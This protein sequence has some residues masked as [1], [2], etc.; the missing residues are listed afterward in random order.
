[1]RATPVQIS[2][3]ALSMALVLTAVSGRLGLTDLLSGA[4]G[5]DL[6]AAG[7]LCVGFAVGAG[8]V[9]GIAH[10]TSADELIASAVD[11]LDLPA[12]C[13]GISL[14]DHLRAGD[15]VRLEPGDDRCGLRSVERLPGPARMVCGVG[16]DLNRD[17]VRDIELL[18]GIGPQKSRAI[19]ESRRAD[20]PFESLDDLARVKGIGEKTVERIRPW[21]ESP[22]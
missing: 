13:R 1:M 21:V 15:L 14:P 22:R 9:V 20:G 16:I 11:R 5:P 19:V 2:I 10:G 18:P 7:P 6:S 17:P 4:R 8:E 12:V 3:A